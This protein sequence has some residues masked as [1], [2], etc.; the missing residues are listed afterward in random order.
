MVAGPLVGTVPCAHTR[1]RTCDHISTDTTL[2]GPK[3]SIVIKE[4]FTSQTSYFN[5]LLHLLS[6]LSCSL[7]RTDRHLY[8]VI[9]LRPVPSEKL[10]EHLGNA[11]VN[12]YAALRK[13]SPVFQSQSISIPTAILCTTQKSV[14]LSSALEIG[15][16]SDR[17]CGSA[18]FPTWYQSAARTQ[19]RFLVS[20]SS[21]RARA[22][23]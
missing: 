12:I 16:A 19:C 3:C 5:S 13:I 15:N 20:L 7:R 9:K 18:N 22:N 17:K 8:L 14:V 4:A 1:C 23:F 6:P 21:S 11:M 10:A 2:H